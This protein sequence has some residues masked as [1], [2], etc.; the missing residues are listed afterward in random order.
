MHTTAPVVAQTVAPAV[1]AA[2]RVVRIYDASEGTA[3]DPL[4]NKSWDLNSSKTIPDM[5][6]V[7]GAEPAPRPAVKAAA[8]TAPS[9]AHKPAAKAR[10]V[11]KPHSQAKP[12]RKPKPAAAAAQ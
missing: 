9:A 2:P 8:K 12:A 6:P 1:P 3:L 7:G 5:P 11:R 10:P 4:R